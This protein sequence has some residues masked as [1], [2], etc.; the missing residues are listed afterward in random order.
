M[1][2]LFSSRL[3]RILSLYH[4]SHFTF[5]KARNF[6]NFVEQSGQVTSRSESFSK[7]YSDSILAADLIDPR[8]PVRGSLIMKPR[9]YAIWELLQKQL[10]EKIQEKGARNAY[11]PL[12]V[13]TSFLSKEA[14]HVDG[15]AK[16]C[17]VVTHHRL[18]VTDQT[19]VGVNKE[20]LMVEPDPNAKLSEPL[21]IRPTSET[22]IW[23]AFS[24]WAVSHRDLPIL[25]NQWANVLRWEL[26]TRPF[27]RTSEFLW[28]EGHTAHA[29]RDEALIYAEGISVLYETF[30]RDVMAIPCF[31]GKKSTSER[32]AGAD[33]TLTCEVILQNGWALQ[34]ATS[35]FLGQHFSKAFNVYYTSQLGQRELAWG[36]S[37]GASTRL[38]GALI[39]SHSDNTGLVLPPRAAPTQVVIVPIC[40]KKASAIEKADLIKQ[41]EGLLRDLTVPLSTTTR[42]T[43]NGDSSIDISGRGFETIILPGKGL[44]VVLDKD[45]DSPP[46]SRFYKWERR[47]VPLRLEVGAR[48]IKAGRATVSLRTK[49]YIPLDKEQENIIVPLDNGSQ[50]RLAVYALLQSFHT[51][52]YERAVERTN[53]LVIRSSLYADMKANAQEA[54]DEKNS[55]EAEDEEDIVCVGAD[56]ASTP[57]L[58]KSS[59]EGEGVGEYKPITRAFLVPWAD[60]AVAEAAIKTETKFTLRCFP[61]EYQLDLKSDAKCFY[62]GKKATHMALFARA[63]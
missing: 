20:T 29:T 32:F 12:L 49:A 56:S 43:L 28:Q 14:A 18:R 34:S 4:S 36:T 27:L 40:G 48:D 44:R 52:L 15:F 7:W 50:A 9:G 8:S 53:K 51:K 19:T 37:W 33:D 60:D 5:Y 24:R 10:D 41:C 22:L 47:G 21:V 2:T 61:I 1:N 17:A 45:I 11:F 46:G 38:I 42:T 54:S 59:K 39:L 35:H 3:Q 63:Y 23:D 25:I 6:A 58:R 13:P 26:R 57:S 55:N 62:S 16:E 30:L 31:L